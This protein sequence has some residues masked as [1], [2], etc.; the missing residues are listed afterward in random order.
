MLSTPAPPSIISFPASPLMISAPAAPEIVS[1]PPPPEIVSAADP[2]IN[3][4]V[5]FGEPIIVDGYN[6]VP[7]LEDIVR[8]VVPVIPDASTELRTVLELVPRVIPCEP[9]NVIDVVEAFVTAPVLI[10]AIALPF[11]IFTVSY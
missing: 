7:E 9:L 8:P 1:I 4:S 6:T 11:V 5:P 3:V 10:A 2:P